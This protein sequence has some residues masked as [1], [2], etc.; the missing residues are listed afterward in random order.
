MNYEKKKEIADA[1]LIDIIGVC[2]NDLADINSLHDCETKEDIIAACNERLGE[3]GM[4]I[5]Q[6]SE[7]VA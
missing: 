5:D 4:V 2:W 7:D 6:S 1:Y 3:E